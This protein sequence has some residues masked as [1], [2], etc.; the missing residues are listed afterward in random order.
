M[1]CTLLGL[2]LLVTGQVVLE[3]IW[4]GLFCLKHDRVLY[5]RRFVRLL[6]CKY[7]LGPTD[8]NALLLLF[9]LFLLGRYIYRFLSHLYIV[10]N[11]GRVRHVTVIL[12]SILSSQLFVNY[13]LGL[14]LVSNNGLEHFVISGVDVGGALVHVGG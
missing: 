5:Q 1:L 9:I 7:I 3:D 4:C 6:N 14:I 13:Y 10:F 2:S 8:Y 12:F 11:F